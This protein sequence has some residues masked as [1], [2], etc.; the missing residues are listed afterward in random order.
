ME[1]PLVGSRL[2]NRLSSNDTNSFTNLTKLT[3]SQIETVTRLTASALRLTSERAPN[4]QAFMAHILN[5]N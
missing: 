5:S 3:S 2:T 4:L 1:K